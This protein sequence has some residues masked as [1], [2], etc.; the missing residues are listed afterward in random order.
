MTRPTPPRVIP[1]TRRDLAT[2]NRQS[3]VCPALGR[4]VAAIAK[5]REAA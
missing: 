3:Q 4:V 1:P 5:R 2:V